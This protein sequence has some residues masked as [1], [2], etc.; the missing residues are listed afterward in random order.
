MSPKTI[1][2]VGSRLGD[3]SIKLSD[4]IGVISDTKKWRA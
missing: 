4:G 3:Y 1:S 2:N